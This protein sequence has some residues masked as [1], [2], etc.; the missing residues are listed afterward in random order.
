MMSHNF[1]DN[2]LQP[3]YILY[4]FGRFRNV[5]LFNANEVADWIRQCALNCEPAFVSVQPKNSIYRIFFDFD[6]ENKREAWLDCLRVYHKLEAFGAKPLIFD[7]GNRGYHLYAYVADCPITFENNQRI[8]AFKTYRELVQ[9]ILGCEWTRI[10]K[11]Y[12]TL[13][14]T[15]LHLAALCRLPYSIHEKTGKQVLPISLEHKVLEEV[16][17][18]EHKQ[19]HIL[20]NFVKLAVKEALKKQNKKIEDCDQLGHFHIRP[21]IVNA[22]KRSP[23]HEVRLAYVLDALFA[24]VP[25]DKIVDAFRFCDDFDEKQT[26]YQID[27]TIRRIKQNGLRPFKEETL[28]KLGICDGSCMTWFKRPRGHS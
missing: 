12:P 13:D 6:A 25:K 19:R 2:W 8:L 1:W 24:G 22:L 18:A 11:L 4:T 10:K 5:K 16:D 23:D 9:L 26:R 27:Y 21:C 17:L 14:T 28:K 15:P 3:D 20:D 7:T